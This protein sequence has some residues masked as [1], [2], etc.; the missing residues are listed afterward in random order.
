M[1]LKKLMVILFR[2]IVKLGTHRL[3]LIDF[4]FSM[5][6]SR[7]FRTYCG[8]PSYMSPEL[9]KKEEYDGIGVDLWSIGVIL[10]KMVTGEYP[11]GSEKDKFLTKKIKNVDVKFPNHLTLS[12]KQLIME[13]LKLESKQRYTGEQ[14]DNHFWFKVKDRDLL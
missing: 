1:K 5:F 10:F 12:C 3:K 14:I 11:F 6:A 7:K 9:V 13:C 2:V 4:G 8:T